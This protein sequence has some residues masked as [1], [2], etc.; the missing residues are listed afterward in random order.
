MVKTNGVYL[1]GCAIV[2]FEV[3]ISHQMLAIEVHYVFE[4]IYV[5]C[6]IKLW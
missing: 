1:R 3:V 2:L 6:R 4:I 5:L